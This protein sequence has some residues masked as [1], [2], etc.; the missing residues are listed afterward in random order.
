MDHRLRLVR[1]LRERHRTPPTSTESQLV[2]MGT[3]ASGL[4]EMLWAW[5]GY[6]AHSWWAWINVREA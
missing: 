4:L 2:C 1:V 3:G 5:R 6:P